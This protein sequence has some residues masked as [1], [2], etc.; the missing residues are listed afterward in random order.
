MRNITSMR[1]ITS[2]KKIIALALSI[3]IIAFAIMPIGVFAESSE[4]KN[5]LEEVIKAVKSKFDISEKFKFTD[6]YVS[7]NEKGVKT[8][9]L[10]WADEANDIGISVSITNKGVITRYYY[11]EPYVQSEKKFPKVS[12]EEALAAAYNFI[13][14]IAPEGT[15]EQ[16]ELQNSV[17]NQIVFLKDQYYF[18]YHRVVNGIPYYENGINISV[19]TETGKVVYYNYNIEDDLIFPPLDGIISLEDA[20]KAYEDNLGL[21]LIY[22]YYYDY[23]KE[24]MDVYP[25]YVPKYD[26]NLYAV[27]AKTGDKIRIG[28]AYYYDERGLGSSA[29]M[30]NEK[31]KLS[32]ASGEAM[33]PVLTPEEIEAV[34]KQAE[35]LSEKDAESIIREAPEIGLTDDYELTG[36][37][38]GKMW[39]EKDKFVYNLTFRKTSEGDNV[40]GY[41][42]LYAWA[43]INA[44]TGEVV[45]FSVDS[46]YTEEK[47]KYDK[48]SAKAEVEKF[49]Q[50]FKPDKFAQTLI[51]DAEEEYDVIT[52]STE[53]EM[54]R[55]YYF[56]YIRQVNGI[57]FPDN[58]LFVTF[59]AVN[60]RVMSFNME[61]FD[62]DFPGLEN[63]ISSGDA[64][65]ALFEN[66]GLELQY[67]IVNET[68][69]IVPLEETSE[70]NPETESSE[71]ES[72]S[73][74]ETSNEENAVEETS[75]EEI[76]IDNLSDK[77]LLRIAAGEE[78]IVKEQN[79][80]VQIK[81]VYVLKSGK[82]YIIDANTGV[83]L[84]YTGKPYQETKIPEYTDIEGHF[85]EEQIKTLVKFGIITFSG[86]EYKP[87]EKITQKDFL[88]ILSNIMDNYYGP[89]VKEDSEQ[90]DIDEMYKQLIRAGI[91]KEGE[92]APESYVVREEAVKFIIR[93]LNYDEV[94]DI[95]E[96][97]K[98]PFEDEDE[99]TPELKGYVA[100]AGGLKIVVGSGG[101]FY[102]KN[103]LTRAEAAVMIYNYLNRK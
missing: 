42:F 72:Q 87:N 96:I 63:V 9:R 62:V 69:D 53:S 26:N 103:N 67:K 97:F 80:E 70:E 56:S 82:P 3:L 50:S 45:S 83:I 11:S 59:D 51:E 15:L 4:E 39:N 31:A 92:K 94:A 52:E 32:Y 86:D 58:G 22:T 88:M 66:I 34:K 48:E 68:D 28:L 37:N 71:S 19:N 36:I 61:W 44:K 73:E 29:D 2:M 18:T 101:K 64:H 99:I 65:R 35:L 25:V 90:D 81:A 77:D 7:T 14:E 40:K 95:S 38:L 13:K 20:E 5:E 60:G 30:Q 24:K 49:L 93:V 54:P 46:D 12:E 78:I 17:D 57:P 84:D 85:A 43:S 91:V 100:I 47:P 23:K 1:S 75:E 98:V 33:E 27:D 8:W 10:N 41:S 74:E 55:F 6:Y 76:S 89:V 102:P 79:K 21:K 16:I